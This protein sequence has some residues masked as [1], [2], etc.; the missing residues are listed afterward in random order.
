M[1]KHRLRVIERDVDGAMARR[2]GVESGH[3]G[4]TGEAARLVELHGEAKARRVGVV[5]CAD[6]VTQVAVPLLAAQRIEGV[7]AREPNIQL[8]AGLPESVK[9]VQ[10]EIGGGVNLEAQLADEANAQAEGEA[11]GDLDLAPVRVT[12]GLV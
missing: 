4:A 8:L 12:L 10:C 5:G 6:V 1:H 3:R 9:H 7:V 2:A 11:V